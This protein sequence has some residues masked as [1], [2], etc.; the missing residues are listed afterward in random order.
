MQ[1]NSISKHGCVNPTKLLKQSI[2]IEEYPHDV[3]P[4]MRHNVFLEAIKASKK[5]K[6]LSV[7]RPFFRRSKKNW[8]NRSSKQFCQNLEQKLM[9]KFFLIHTH[10]YCTAFV[11][12][13]LPCKTNRMQAFDLTQS[14]KTWFFE[15]FASYWGRKKPIQIALNVCLSWKNQFNGVSKQPNLWKALT[16]T[17]KQKKG[18]FRFPLKFFS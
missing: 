4:K 14:K 11:C 7:K 13:R 5:S 6:K 15:V 8:E 18:F 2:E 12:W 9:K 3:S 16:K 1:L 10:M 17:E